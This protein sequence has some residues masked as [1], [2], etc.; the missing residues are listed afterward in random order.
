MDFH[1]AQESL[2]ILEWI[3]RATVGFIFLLIAA[4]IMGQRSISQLRF[5]DFVIALL[6]GNIIAHPLS[7]EGLGL[8]GSMITMTVIV[9]LYVL[10]VWGSLKST[11]FRGLFNPP[12]IPLIEGGEINYK[13]LKKARISIEVLLSELRK[14]QTEDIQKVALALWEAGGFISIFLYPK[15]LPLTPSNPTAKIEP[16][17]FPRSI[18]IE[19]KIDYKELQ[20]I[21]ENQQWLI[22]QLAA[23]NVIPND[24]LLA[25]IDIND[26][27]KLYL[28]K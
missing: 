17:N 21:G 14:E 13:N 20:Q 27:L 18:I 6:L 24:V 12:P 19:G 7:D 11:A 10:G 28:F 2:T 23:Q 9:T 5:L 4:K 22:D 16:F 8:R 25:T 3:M 1:L 15:F 26:K